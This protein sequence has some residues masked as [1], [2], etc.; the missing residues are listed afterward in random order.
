MDAIVDIDGREIVADVEL[1]AGDLWVFGY[2][3]VMWRPDFPALESHRARLFGFHR[4]LCVWSWW[5]RGSREAPGLVLGLDIG[6]SCVGQAYR[7][8]AVDKQAV[9]RLLYAREMVTPVYRPHLR[10]VHLAGKQVTA[11][12]FLVDRSHPQYAGRLS[13]HEAAAVVRHARG[14]SGANPDY[15]A[16]TVG[17]LREIGLKDAWLEQTHA[18][19]SGG[20]Y[21]DE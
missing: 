4:A 11:L 10:S 1:P 5:H 3:S 14:A 18:L 12:T 6:G 21:S 16:S 17:H 20:R 9:A 7:V 13:P 2:G 8:A 15:L 19:V